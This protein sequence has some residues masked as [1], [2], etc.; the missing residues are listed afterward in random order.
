[1][2]EIQPTRVGAG[3][4][5]SSVAQWAERNVVSPFFDEAVMEPVRTVAQYLDPEMRNRRSGALH[6]D[7]EAQRLTRTESVT[8]TVAK[9]IGSVVPYVVAGLAAEKGLGFLADSAVPEGALASF[10]TKPAVGQTV[11]AVAYDALRGPRGSETRVGNSASTA[12]SFSMFGLGNELAAALPG[13]ESIALRLATGAI[14]GAGGAM[15]SQELGKTHS[16]RWGDAATAGLGG[17]LLNGLLPSGR[18]AAQR[19]DEGAGVFAK[20]YKNEIRMSIGGRQ[21]LAEYLNSLA[22][23]EESG[24][25]NS[26]RFIGRMALTDTELKLPADKLKG[27]PTPDLAWRGESETPSIDITDFNRAQRNSLA[28]QLEKMSSTPFQDPRKM[29]ALAKS[30]ELGTAH[31]KEQPLEAM[32]KQ[33]SE[34]MQHAQGHLDAGNEE[35]AGNMEPELN[36]LSGDIEAIYGGRAK[37]VETQLNQWARASKLPEITVGLTD[38][39]GLIATYEPGKGN[40]LLGVKAIADDDLN[41]KIVGAASH[42]YTHLLQD[43]EQIRAIAD[44]LGIG[45][46]ASPEQ[47]KTIAEE[48][49]RAT[50]RTPTDDFIERTIKY[51]DGKALS[52]EELKHS[53]FINDSLASYDEVKPLRLYSPFN[54]VLGALEHVRGALNDYAAGMSED[55]AA[56]FGNAVENMKNSISKVPELAKVSSL[57]QDAEST[58]DRSAKFGPEFV[59]QLGQQ[60]DIVANELRSMREA[61]YQSYASFDFEKE[62]L[63]TGYLTS[64]YYRA[65]KGSK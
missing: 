35:A 24:A 15:V 3:E 33:F 9:S 23:R 49:Q 16:I 52:P 62:A 12:F 65:L 54:R 34:M 32:K 46:T 43:T 64:L 48:F 59:A 26:N 11:G 5:T 30:I 40:M 56:E 44:R 41:A 42:E 8:R 37:D 20:A 60:I 57:L 7:R 22:G 21:P 51:R 45:Q 19:I 1:M 36:R 29:Q 13:P 53:Q 63:S 55:D 6:P 28:L 31:W 58:V 17:A 27:H 4:H 18:N 25:I 2:S 39:P 61:A 50:R 10:L 14:G 38:Q 47:L